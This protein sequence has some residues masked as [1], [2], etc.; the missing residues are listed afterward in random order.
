MTPEQYLSGLTEG[1]IY[2][3]TYDNNGD[4]QYNLLGNIIG[5]DEIGAQWLYQ[6]VCSWFNNSEAKTAR[7]NPATTPEKVSLPNNGASQ[8]IRRGVYPKPKHYYQNFDDDPW[9]NYYAGQISANVSYIFPFTKTS[10]IL[11]GP[12]DGLQKNSGT[13]K[14]LGLDFINDTTVA[15]PNGSI[16]KT[17]EIVGEP[18]GSFKSYYAV[19]SID[20]APLFSNNIIVTGGGYQYYFITDTGA[21]SQPTET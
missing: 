21:V 7:V 1:A 19:L 16:I 2:T 14:M 20:Y 18:R 9:Y 13:F 10:L 12:Y 4:V 15:L 17:G 6:K 8:Y 5:E 11:T 3:F